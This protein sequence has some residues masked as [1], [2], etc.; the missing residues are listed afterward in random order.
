[1]ANESEL[2]SIH[3]EIETIYHKSV[4]HIHCDIVHRFVDEQQARIEALETAIQTEIDYQEGNYGEVADYL[5][6]VVPQRIDS[7]DMEGDEPTN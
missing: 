7:T 5:L 1:M 2:K 4:D 3:E 6:A